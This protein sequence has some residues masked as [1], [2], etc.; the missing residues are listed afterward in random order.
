[1]PKITISKVSDGIKTIISESEV[2]QEKIDKI[3]AT[4]SKM[5]A[6]KEARMKKRF[7]EIPDINWEILKYCNDHKKDE[8]ILKYP[9]HKKF[10]DTVRLND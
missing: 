7:D 6:D 5:R 10:I 9:N 4:F 1:M 3:K 2:S 8:V